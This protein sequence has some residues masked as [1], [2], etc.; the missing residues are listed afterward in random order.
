[1][2]VLSVLDQSPIRSG[3]TAV[4]AIRE[5][6]LIWLHG[7]RYGPY[8]SVEEAED[9]PYSARERALVEHNRRRAFAS[10]NSWPKPS[11]W[12]GRGPLVKCGGFDYSEM[13]GM[14]ERDDKVT[15][16]ASS[17]SGKEGGSV[18]LRSGLMNGLTWEAML[19]A[20]PPDSLSGQAVL[21]LDNEEVL[22]PEDAA[23]GEFSILEAAL[24]EREALRQAGYTLPDWTP[25]PPPA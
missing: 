7:R 14:E 8:P 19:T 21:A 9:N 16:V 18:K 5:I 17:P 2:I 3:G 15:K 23:F 20:E 4:D 6:L 24:G 1:M 25:D 13:R 12:T 11:D 10:T 22:S